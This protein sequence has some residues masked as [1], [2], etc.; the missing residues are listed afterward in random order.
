[1]PEKNA[2]VDHDGEVTLADLARI[3]QYLSK[4]IE[5]FDK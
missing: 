4:K 3:R 2:D 5:S 1:M